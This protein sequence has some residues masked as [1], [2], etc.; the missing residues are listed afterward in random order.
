MSGPAADDP[1]PDRA[2]A[3]H[4]GP[5][6]A[7]GG[8]AR[9]DRRA[10]RRAAMRELAAAVRRLNDATVRSACAPDEVRAVAA[11][12]HELAARLEA[13]HHPGPYSGLLAQREAGG[14]QDPH[15]FLPLMPMAGEFNPIAPPL[16]IEVRDGRAYG[17]VTLGRQ[18]TGP[19]GVAHGGTLASLCDQMVAAAGWCVGIEGVTKWLRVEFR[20]PAPLDEPLQLEAVSTRLDERRTKG[21]VWIRSGAVLC[22]WAE[23]ETVLAASVTKR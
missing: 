4:T 20:K 1:T 5:A 17:T 2:E 12:T 14:W 21:E 22:V 9:A 13:E 23:A 7:D 11:A 10:D 18:H 6:H 16:R 15:D 8:D 19:P 3:I